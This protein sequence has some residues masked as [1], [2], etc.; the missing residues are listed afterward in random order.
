[1]SEIVYIWTDEGVMKPLSY[2]ANH[3]DENF[4]VGQKYKLREVKERSIK[5][6]DHYFACLHDAWQTLP[7]T[8]E[9]Q[10]VNEEKFRKW[11]LIQAGFYTENVFLMASNEEAWRMAREYKDVDIY[12]EVIV[13]GNLIAIRK[14]MSQKI[15]RKDGDG[16]MDAETFQKSKEGVLDV[17]AKLI[18][19]HPTELRRRATEL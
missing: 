3:C 13:N 2:F 5:S 15:K 18:G 16:G 4:I 9:A 17:V 11:A 8:V 14:A 7:E 1:M 10:F 19:V 12:A 6:H